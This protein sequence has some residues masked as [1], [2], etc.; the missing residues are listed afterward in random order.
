M[1]VC[2]MSRVGACRWPVGGSEGGMK[3]YEDAHESIRG[4]TQKHTWTH[5]AQPHTHSHTH[6]QLVHAYRQTHTTHC[7]PHH[8]R[9]LCTYL[10]HG[11][12]GPKAEATEERAVGAAALAFFRCVWPAPLTLPL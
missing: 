10:L 3:A 8:H 5:A 2:V 11:T 1:C 4:R 12:S 6:A 9:R 7:A